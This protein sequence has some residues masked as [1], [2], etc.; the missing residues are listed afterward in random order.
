[1][2]TTAC[3]WPAES[4]KGYQSPGTGCEQ[5]SVFWKLISG[6]LQKQ[7]APS[8]WSQPYLQPFSVWLWFLFCFKLDLAMFPRL[9]GSR[10][11]PASAQQAGSGERV[12]ASP[13]AGWLPKHVLPRLS[14]VRKNV[15]FPLQEAHLQSSGGTR[16]DQ[17]GSGWCHGQQPAQCLMVSE[18]SSP[19]IFPCDPFDKG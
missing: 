8:Q 3:L 5:T 6:P 2:G 16:R 4:R 13:C 12:A 10:Y 14:Q 1:M 17:E 9:L 11:P 7:Q 15:D 18:S 19:Y